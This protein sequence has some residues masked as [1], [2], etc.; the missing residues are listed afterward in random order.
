M[1]LGPTY[2]S[3]LEVTNS[4]CGGDWRVRFRCETAKR[5]IVILRVLLRGRAYER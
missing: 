2:A 4:D 5:E 1:I 3:S